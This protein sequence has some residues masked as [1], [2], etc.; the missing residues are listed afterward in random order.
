MGIMTASHCENSNQHKKKIYKNKKR[1]RKIIELLINKLYILLYTRSYQ[2]DFPDFCGSLHCL[3][4]YIYIYINSLRNHQKKKNIYI[5]IY[6]YIYNLSLSLYIYIAFLCSSLQAFSPI[7][8]L[9]SWWCIYTIVLTWQ[10]LWR[11]PVS[12]YQWSDFHM[13]DDQPMT[14]YTF[15]MHIFVVLSS[16]FSIHNG[17]FQ[18]G[19]NIWL[20]STQGLDSKSYT[21]NIVLLVLL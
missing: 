11:I 13:I 1:K 3:Y 12:F 18:E 5:Y 9:D 14:I 17:L 16:L 21:G 19:Y 8:L 10:Q 7:T 6:I 4:I 2:D 20:S 15:P